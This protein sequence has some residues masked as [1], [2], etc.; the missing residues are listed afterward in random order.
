MAK[1]K[2]SAKLEMMKPPHFDGIGAMRP[3]ASAGPPRSALKPRNR[4]KLV[5]FLVAESV[6]IAILIVSVLAALSLRFA[7]ESWTPVFRVL[8]VGAA[9]VA[10][11]LPIAFYGN[12]RRRRR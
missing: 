3:Q 12:G 8:P 5:L 1:L 4:P 10:T 11:V 6:A 2:R 9:I 7:S